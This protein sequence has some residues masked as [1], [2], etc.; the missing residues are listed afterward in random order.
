MLLPAWKAVKLIWLGYG[1]AIKLN[2]LTDVSYKE[3][4]LAPV[5]SVPDVVRVTASGAV[6]VAV[7]R[8]NYANLRTYYYVNGVKNILTSYSDTSNAGTVDFEN[9]IVT[10]NNFN[11]VLLNSSDGIL[12]VNAYASNRIVSSS[13]DKIITLDS[14]DSSAI[15]VNVTTK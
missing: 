3:T 15:T 4:D 11:P 5:T 12:R 6:G 1:L 9:G 10:L 2:L 14:N 7:I 8:G 13:Y